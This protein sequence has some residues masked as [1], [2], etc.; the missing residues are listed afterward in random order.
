MSIMNELQTKYKA[1][2]IGI[3]LVALLPLAFAATNKQRFTSFT[4]STYIIQAVAKHYEIDMH[5]CIKCQKNGWKFGSILV[6]FL[7][8]VI[9]FSFVISLTS[10]AIVMTLFAGW[11]LGFTIQI[12]LLGRYPDTWKVTNT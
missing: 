11:S 4:E 12:L 1:L 9:L 2:I 10:I 6:I 7:V 3:S 8:L 5:E